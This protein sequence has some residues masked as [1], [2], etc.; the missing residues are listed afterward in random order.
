MKLK[1]LLLSLALAIPSSAALA[2]PA[3][4]VVGAIIGA[5]VAQPRVIYAQ[6]A[7]PYGQSIYAAPVYVVPQVPVYQI[8][9]TRT[10][11]IVIDHS[12]DAYCPYQGDLYFRC[13]GNIQRKKMEEAF[14]QGFNGR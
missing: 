7:Y 10:Q 14:M 11:N 4:F 9:T 8:D 12:L 5:A 2:D 13:Q 3:S 6:P 1:T